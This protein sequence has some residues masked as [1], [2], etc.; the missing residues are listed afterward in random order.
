MRISCQQAFRMS[1]H[2][3]N[4]IYLLGPPTYWRFIGCCLQ[5]LYASE[6]LLTILTNEINTFCGLR[7]QFLGAVF[8]QRRWIVNSHAAIHNRYDVGILIPAVLKGMKLLAY[9]NKCNLA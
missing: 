3:L 2:V 9:M 5:Q 8:R 7:E 4:F 6:D 1:K